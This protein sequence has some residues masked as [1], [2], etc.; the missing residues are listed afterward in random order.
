MSRLQRRLRMSGL[1]RV[2]R[3]DPEQHRLELDLRNRSARRARGLLQRMEPMLLLTPPWSSPRPILEALAL[4]MAMAEPPLRCRTLSL[5]PLRNRERHEVW[6]WLLTAFAGLDGG[7]HIDFPYVASTV[8]FRTGLL[9]V[10]MRLQDH[11]SVPT[12]LLVHDGE[13]L[14][15]EVR[16]ALTEAWAQLHQRLPTDRR[17]EMILAGS[18]RPLCS[19]GL[20]TLTLKDYG[21]LEATEALERLLP[22]A[23]EQLDLAV[24]F[25]GG[26]PEVLGSMASHLRTL[27][28]VPISTSGLLRS[29]GPLE[30][31]LAATVAS[32][33]RHPQLSKRLTDLS[34]GQMLSR[35]PEMDEPLLA[36]GLLVAQ[37]EDTV[38][39]RAPLFS[40]LGA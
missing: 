4:E 19:S 30:R 20:P 35:E 34:E 5:A 6:K 16:T 9:D 26:I 11:I 22:S 15:D 37:K 40:A 29:L 25:S 33:H 39:L 31:D 27:G 3:F 2:S 21:V 8:G 10:L 1:Q 17:V 36:A 7:K 13:V 24:T 12:A 18:F 38:S 32:A 28:S 14:P 23:T